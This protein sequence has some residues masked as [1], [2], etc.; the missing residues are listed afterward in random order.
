MSP[1]PRDDVAFSINN[2][3][4]AAGWRSLIEF[5]RFGGGF[6]CAANCT[7]IAAQGNQGSSFAATNGIDWHLGSFS[8]NTWN[9]GHVVISGS[10]DL[11][12]NTAS[13]LSPTSTAGFIH[14][15]TVAGIPSATPQLNSGASCVIDTTSGS[16][17]LFC[18]FN[19]AWHRIEF[20]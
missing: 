10:G 16:A 17:F 3:S 1:H 18:F 5:G 13:P 9:D 8:G 11:L 4:G 14:L 20:D 2:A 15:P 7:L 12:A 6:P 19:S